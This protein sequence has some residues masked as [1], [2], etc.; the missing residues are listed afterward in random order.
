[1]VTGIERVELRRICE[2]DEATLVN[3]LPAREHEEEHL[4][5]SIS[6]PLRELTAEAVSGLARNQPVVVYCH[7]D[8]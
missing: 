8:L 6:I 2:S 1:M 5:G 3:V 7:D 4:P